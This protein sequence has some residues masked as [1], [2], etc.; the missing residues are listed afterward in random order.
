MH[1]F[2]VSTKH[3]NGRVF[4]SKHWS[5]FETELTTTVMLLYSQQI[6]ATTDYS[7][8]QCLVG[9][10]SCDRL[11]T[12]YLPSHEDSTEQ[13]AR[14][15]DLFNHAFGGRLAEEMNKPEIENRLTKLASRAVYLFK[16]IQGIVS[17]N[18]NQ[19]Y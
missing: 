12:L 2:R 1:F 14:F 19:M 15:K 11:Q 3:C 9:D 17:D 6:L 5:K 10:Y 13:L 7:T 16:E 18:C 4:K 8:L